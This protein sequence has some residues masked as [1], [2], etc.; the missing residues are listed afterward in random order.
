MG[1]WVG[2]GVVCR[3]GLRRGGFWF[4]VEGL[5]LGAEG[6][7][8]VSEIAF[9]GVET[10]CFGLR[11]GEWGDGGERAVGGVLFQVVEHLGGGFGGGGWV[12]FVAV[13]EVVGVLAFLGIV[14]SVFFVVFVILWLDGF[15]GFSGEGGDGDLE[16]VEEEAGAF[17]VEVVGGDAA[18]DLGQGELD[19]GAV[20]EDGHGEGV[21][22][23]VGIAGGVAGDGAAGGVVVE[24]EVLVAEGDHAA[25]AAGGADVA[26]EEAGGLWVGGGLVCGGGFRHG[27]TPPALSKDADSLRLGPELRPAVG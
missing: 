11:F 15:A 17:W 6:C 26:A 21:P 4:G 14:V 2:V 1:L 19:G 20:F 24:A 18:E 10:A 7:V 27:G 22:V 25:A 5:A 3:M 16:A 8:G 12:G 9:E 13:G 23:G